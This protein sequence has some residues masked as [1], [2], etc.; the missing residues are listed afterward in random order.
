MK[1][2]LH[3]ALL[4]AAA[5]VLGPGT[6][7]ALV[8]EYPKKPITMIVPYPAGGATDILARALGEKLTASLGQQVVIDNRPGANGNIGAQI[9]AKAAPD[10]YTLL[11]SPASTLTHNPSLYSK[12]PFDPLKDLAPISIVAETPMVVVVN[13]AIPA[14]SIK[15]LVDLA[16]SKPGAL[17]FASPGTGSSPHLSGELFKVMTKTDMVHVPYKGAAPAVTDLVGGQ[18]QL[19]FDTIVSSLPHVKSGKLRALAVTPAKRS[20]LLPE[21]PTVAEAGVPGYEA[22]TWF[23]LLAPAGTP[24]PIIEKLHNEVVKILKTPDMKSRLDQLGAEPIGNTPEEF[25]AAMKQEMAKW[26]KVVADAGIRLE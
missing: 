3:T 18:V 8:Q 4:L 17:S 7:G 13:P 24:K 10:G 15:E 11:M 16:K 23:G 20:P 12:M 26:A 19:M 1:V 25:T 14:K 9:A 5:A 22:T 6:A 21:L 2:L